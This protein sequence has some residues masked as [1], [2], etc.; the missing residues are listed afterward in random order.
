[1]QF[2]WKPGMQKT[3]QSCKSFGVRVET[4][5]CSQGSLT[6]ENELTAEGSQDVALSFMSICL[7]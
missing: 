3:D 6:G 7:V 4:N 1:L 5:E 2:I